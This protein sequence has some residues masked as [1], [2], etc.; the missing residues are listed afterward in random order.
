M[1]GVRRV[2]YHLPEVIAAE[3]VLVVEG[4]KDVETARTFGFVATTNAEGAGKWTRHP[5]LFKGVVCATFNIENPGP[6]REEKTHDEQQRAICT[7]IVQIQS[8]ANHFVS[9]G[10]YVHHPH[11]PSHMSNWW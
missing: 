8:S 2:P 9:D 11:S 10:L 3:K 1:N 4:E 6:I 5:P 7:K